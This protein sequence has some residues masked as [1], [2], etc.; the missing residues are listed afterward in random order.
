[1]NVDYFNQKYGNNT[2]DTRIQKSDAFGFDVFTSYMNNDQEEMRASD[3][4]HYQKLEGTPEVK[5]LPIYKRLKKNE[6]CFAVN[7]ELIE[8]QD[9]EREIHNKLGKVKFVQYVNEYDA[10]SYCEGWIPGCN[11]PQLYFKVKGVWTGGHQ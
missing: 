8:K 5:K 1:M 4:I 11:N 3:Y 9:I 6:V 7:V 2:F 10:L